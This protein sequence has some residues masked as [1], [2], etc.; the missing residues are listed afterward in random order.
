MDFDNHPC[1]SAKARRQTGRIHLPVAPKCNIQC[2]FCNRKY[3]CAGECRP[4][5]TSHILA[6]P[7]AAAYLDS[8][9]E[10]IGNISVVGIAGP[11]DP[12]ANPE[13]TLTTLELVREKHPGMTLCVA[14]NG[15]ALADYVDELARLKVSHV[16]VTLNA[17]DSEIGRKIYPWVRPGKSIYR[18]SE[19]AEILLERQTEGIK[20][21]KAKGITVKINTVI[22]PGINDAHARQVARYAAGLGADIQNCIPMIHVE[23]TVFENLEAPDA[24]AMAAVRLASGKHLAQMSHCARCRA[25]AAGFIGEENSARRESLLADAVMPKPSAAKP[26][27]AVASM[28]GL[29]VNRHLGE[30]AQ[31]WIFGMEDGKVKLVEQ[32]PTPEP[33]AGEGRWEKLAEILADCAALQVSGCGPTPKKIL[34]RRGIPVMAIEGLIT[35]T[36]R[37]VLE[38]REIPKVYMARAGKCGAGT[39]CGGEG[40]GCG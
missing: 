9:L 2:N 23:G 10:K 36:V 24:A 33:G 30:A 38:G 29:F 27:V 31:V 26:Y 17:V 40:L 18:G 25:D 14:T 8:V 16:T 34:E 39:S 3:E 5:V 1:F 15:L 11:G 12:F 6:P 21:L 19:G 32:R 35:E 20:L 13:E 28:E 22:I 37:P 4:G 7:Q